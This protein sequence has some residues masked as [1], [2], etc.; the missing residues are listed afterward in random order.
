MCYLQKKVTTKRSLLS[1]L[2]NVL[3]VHLQRLSYNSESL[4]NIKINSRHD[5]PGVLK[6][7]QNYTVEEI[8]KLITSDKKVLDTDEVYVKCSEYIYIY[9][10]YIL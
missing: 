7:L 3:I 8:S 1:E 9:I 4:K 5:F 2:P 10:Y 6:T